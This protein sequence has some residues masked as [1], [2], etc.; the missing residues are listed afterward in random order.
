MSDNDLAK[1]IAENSQWIIM[2]S[3]FLLGVAA[4]KARTYVSDLGHLRRVRECLANGRPYVA[5]TIVE[6][7]MSYYGGTGYMPKRW[8]RILPDVPGLMIYDDSGRGLRN[9]E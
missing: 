5:R 6:E 3:T 4:E 2:V 8:Q 1:R 9:A 7:R